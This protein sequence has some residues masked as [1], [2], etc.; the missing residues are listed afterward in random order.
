MLAFAVL[1][2][3]TRF[4]R[5][6]DM[7]EMDKQRQQQFERCTQLVAEDGGLTARETEIFALLVRG[8]DRA[9]IREQLCI[10]ND[11]VKTHTRR[12]YAKLGIHAKQEARALVEAC[13]DREERGM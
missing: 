1:F 8:K 11:T 3:R 4:D 7:R 10:S 9:A 13:M 5:S 2:G 6:R 12:I